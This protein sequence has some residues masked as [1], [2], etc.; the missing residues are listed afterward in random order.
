[1][2]NK[3]T[4]TSSHKEVGNGSQ[5]IIESVPNEKIIS[6]LDFGRGEPP[7]GSFTFTPE[8]EAT[9]VVWGVDMDMGMNPMG[10]VFGLFMDGMMGKE[11][12]AGL[13]NLKAHVESLPDE[14]PPVADATTIDSLKTTNAP[15]VT[16]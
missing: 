8:G 14:A 3:N 13:N 9:K 6:K 4:W 12:E 5:E 2:G 7:I 11:F 10:K 1:V 15:A 16:N